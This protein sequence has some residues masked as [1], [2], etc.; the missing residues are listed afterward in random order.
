[1]TAYTPSSTLIINPLAI[2]I[3]SIA[4]CTVAVSI[5]DNPDVGY[6]VGKAQAYKKLK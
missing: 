4:L 1:M 2:V 6:R 3:I 5:S